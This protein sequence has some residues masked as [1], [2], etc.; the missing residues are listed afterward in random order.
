MADHDHQR[1]VHASLEH[2]AASIDTPYEECT[3]GW[4]EI[5]DREKAAVRAERLR[6]EKRAAHAA[7]RAVIKVRRTR[8]VDLPQVGSFG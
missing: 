5:S 8:D 6:E 7:A 2:L 4:K 3:C 1:Y